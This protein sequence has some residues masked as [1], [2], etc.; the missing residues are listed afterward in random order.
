SGNV[1]MRHHECEGLLQKTWQHLHISIE[2]VDK[3]TS[4][5]L[6]TQLRSGSTALLIAMFQ[7]HDAYGVPHRS[8]H[9][10]IGRERVCQDDLTIQSCDGLQRTFD[11]G[12]NVLFLI[13]CLDDD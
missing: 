12:L 13:Q 7:L 3:R 1:A 6:I 2:N 4:R 11:R 5:M 8:L 9:R 10:T